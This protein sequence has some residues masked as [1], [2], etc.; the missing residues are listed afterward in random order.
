MRGN[1]ELYATLC[2]NGDDINKFT[3]SIRMQC[4]FRFIDENT[5]I[6]REIP[7]SEQRIKDSCFLCAFRSRAYWETDTSLLAQGL[8]KVKFKKIRKF[9]FF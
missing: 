4:R 7:V 1:K 6:L 5:G 2:K 8:M 3:D 9:V